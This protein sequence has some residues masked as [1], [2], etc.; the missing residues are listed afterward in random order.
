VEPEAD[1]P[2]ES[3]RLLVRSRADRKDAWNLQLWGEIQEAEGQILKVREDATKNES[4][5]GGH[6]KRPGR[7]LCRVAFRSGFGGVQ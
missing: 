6:K 1:M 3:K 4:V 5:L 2:L 7:Y